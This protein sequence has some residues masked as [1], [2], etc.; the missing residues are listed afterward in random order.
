MSCSLSA[1]VESLRGNIEIFRLRK[2]E[3]QG[4]MEDMF[5][6]IVLLSE[7]SFDENNLRMNNS[8]EMSERNEILQRNAVNGNSFRFEKFKKVGKIKFWRN[9][10]CGNFGRRN[11]NNDYHGNTKGNCQMRNLH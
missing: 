1:N 7:L 9:L 10:C 2:E 8:L 4:P 5:G 11:H 3:A 6:T